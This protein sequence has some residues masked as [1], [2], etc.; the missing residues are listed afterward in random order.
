MRRIL[1]HVA[2]KRTSAI[3]RHAQTKVDTY[4][5]RINTIFAASIVRETMS[6]VELI[7]KHVP[8]VRTAAASTDADRRRG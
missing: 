6:W 3:L 8:R 7:R 4:D 1:I 2:L 5:K